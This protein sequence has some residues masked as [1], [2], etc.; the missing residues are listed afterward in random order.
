MNLQQLLEQTTFDFIGGDPTVDFVDTEVMRQG[1]RIDLL[2]DFEHLVVWLIQAGL[3][4]QD[5]I[6]QKIQHWGEDNESSRVL[7][8][9][10]ELRRTL[11]DIFEQVVEEGYINP[12][13]INALNS[14]LQLYPGYLQLTQTSDGLSR[15]FTHPIKS[16]NDLLFPLVE[17]AVNFL[18]EAN[19]LLIKY[20]GNPECIRYF[21]DSTKNHSRRW[22]SME[23]CGNRMKVAAY[24]QRKRLSS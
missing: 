4:E 16:P 6:A 12:E 22:C 1:E 24:Y 8:K 2:P 9:A 10:R 14:Q 17:S 5:E 18:C 21:H 7:A 19:L 15:Q 11:R 13:K 20:C 23:T 3:L